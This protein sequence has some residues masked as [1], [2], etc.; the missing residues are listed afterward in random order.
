MNMGETIK[1]LRKEKDMTQEQLAEYLNLSAQAVSRWELNSTLPD[2]TLVP[3]LA[4]IFGV[5]TDLLLGVDVTTMENRIGDI[6]NEAINHMWQG[7]ATEGEK[8]LRGGLKEFPNSHQLMREL[9]ISLQQQLGLRFDE[10]QKP[11]YQEII[12]LC[13]KNL[14]ASTDDFIRHSAIQT[15]CFIYNQMGEQE[16]AKTYAKKMPFKCFSR[17]SMLTETLRG[18]EKFAHIQDEL[19]SG[20]LSALMF[21]PRLMDCQ[22]D[23]GAQPFTAD[24]CR[25]LNQKIIDITHLIFEE[26]PLGDFAF[27]LAD[28]HFSLAR[29]FAEEGDA[30]T[31]MQH[32]KQVVNYAIT[33]D[34]MPPVNQATEEH[35]N[36]L[37]KGLKFPFTMPS[38]NR[39]AAEYFLEISVQLDTLLPAA[40]LAEVR[41]ALQKERI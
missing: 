13:E 2:I 9:A 25:A 41:A 40:D 39:I 32:L 20:L 7:N 38:P 27:S 12:A 4:N 10:A 31:A 6:I 11:I 21:I 15:L 18:T 1:R 23:G 37:F 35:S 30:A 3:L 14:A 36:L 24:E 5:T 34:A 16:K 28:A 17:E 33:T 8:I 22:L 29:H 26:G 19:R